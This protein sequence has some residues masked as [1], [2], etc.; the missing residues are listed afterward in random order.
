MMWGCFAGTGTGRLVCV[1]SKMNATIYQDILSQNLMESARQLSL[2]CRFVFQQDNDPKH[3]AKKIKAWFQKKHVDVLDWP[4]QSPG[5]NPIENLWAELKR[6]VHDRQP[7]N[8]AELEAY[9]VEEWAQIPPET[10]RKYVV[11]YKS[12]LLQIIKNKGHSIDY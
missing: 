11:N 1:E 8:L 3:M 5:L 9:C 4:S 6:R 7:Q 2:G 10:C 12:R